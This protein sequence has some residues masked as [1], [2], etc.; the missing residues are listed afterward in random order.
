MSPASE[1]LLDTV[2]ALPES[3]RVEFAEALAASLVP[4]DRTPLIEAWREEIRR[5]SQEWVEGKVTGIPW[6]EVRRQAREKADG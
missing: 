4:S 2:L 5:R 1:Q 6:E 3:E